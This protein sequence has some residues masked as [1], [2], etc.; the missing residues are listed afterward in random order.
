MGGGV[1]SCSWDAR[2]K[3]EESLPHP[4]RNVQAKID[5]Q[6]ISDGPS[7]MPA[8]QYKQIFWLPPGRSG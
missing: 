6:R 3:L 7:K 8:A 4:G 5:R 2:R 1:N